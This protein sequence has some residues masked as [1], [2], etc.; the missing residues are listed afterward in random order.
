M[1]EFGP[2][3]PGSEIGGNSMA[4]RDIPGIHTPYYYY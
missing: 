4:Y 3:R 2:Q 1:T